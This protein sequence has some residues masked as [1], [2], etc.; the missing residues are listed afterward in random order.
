MHQNE[1]QELDPQQNAPTVALPET[2]STSNVQP[3]TLPFGMYADPSSPLY[4]ETFISGAA[5]QVTYTYKKL[6][7]DVLDIELTESNVYAAFEDAVL[8]YAYHINLHQAES[9]LSRMLGSQTGTFDHHGELV[10][11]SAL[12]ASNNGRGIE[13]KYPRHTLRNTRGYSEGY[14]TQIG[15]GKN[16]HQYSA[17][18]ETQQERQDYN[19]QKAL[20]D[21]ANDHIPD[22]VLD[23]Q[24]IITEVFYKTPRASWRFYGYYGGLNVVG[25]LHNYGQYSDDSTFEIVPVW[26]NKLQSIQYEDAIY[27]RL[28]H[29]SY[30][31][32][33]DKIRIYPAPDS[34]GPD[35]IWFR[36]RVPEDPWEEGE[37]ESGVD[38]IN[39][40]NSA[41]FANIPFEKI[42][43]IGKQWIRRY[44]LAVCKEMLGQVRGKFQN[45]PIPGE[46]VTLNASDLLD[47]ART[48]KDELKEELNE[49]LEKLTYDEMA[50]RES[51]TADAIEN[52]QRKSPL[53]IYQK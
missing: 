49:T 22:S 36:F 43:A 52:V 26:Q 51:E 45:I 23:K 33:G 6:G 28:S 9:A 50:Q 4:S 15:V 47:Q 10:S 8:E 40:L 12:S 44:A 32:M 41:P 53:P 5:Q 37:Y 13:L 31:L 1:V 29:F 2:G 27:T 7:G 18:I 46:S 42:N 21:E 39:N 14:A 20:E 17:S 25:N 34:V 24:I 30:E 11:G 38:G 48:E 3:S 19:V 16:A 35:R